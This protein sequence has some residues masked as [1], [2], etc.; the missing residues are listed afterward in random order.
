MAA[1][2]RMRAPVWQV[3][4]MQAARAASPAADRPRLV[5]RRRLLID[6]GSCHVAGC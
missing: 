4:D 1:G 3:Y 6:R 5:L 2:S